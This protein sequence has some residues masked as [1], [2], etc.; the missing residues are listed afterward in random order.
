MKSDSNVFERLV[1]AT[2][3]FGMLALPLISALSWNRSALAFLFMAV[4]YAF[5]SLLSWLLIHE[6]IH[7]KLFQ[8]FGGNLFLGRTIAILFGCPFSILR[9]GHLLHHAHNRMSLDSCR[10]VS[11]HLGALVYRLSYYISILGGLHV[12][13]L[14]LP[15]A[16]SSPFIAKVLSE[17]RPKGS[18]EKMFLN[19]VLRRIWQIRVDTMLCGSYMALAISVNSDSLLPLGALMCI[20]AALISYHDNIYHHGLPADDRQAGHNVPLPDLVAQ[21]LLNSNYHR[22]HHAFP[23]APWRSL[24][25]LAERHRLP[26]TMRPTEALISQLRGPDVAD[27]LLAGDQ[28]AWSRL[29]R[30]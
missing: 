6:C 30:T 7:G 4:L 2:I 28:I 27:H 8:S 24:P 17:R 22:V 19:S 21:C 10:F 5:C 12:V 25:K 11:G 16:V 29:H 14:L 15:W 20:K 18:T 13:Q 9:A 23:A 1:A 26:F 3:A